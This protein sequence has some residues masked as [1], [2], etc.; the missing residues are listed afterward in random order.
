MKIFI[1]LILLS[2]AAG[3]QVYNQEYNPYGSYGSV[4]QVNSYQ[5][6]RS[7][8]DN[9]QRALDEAH[10]RDRQRLEYQRQEERFRES[11]LSERFPAFAI[12]RQ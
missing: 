1:I 9:G 7:N 5:P 3:A 11:P 4:P 10:A 2:S 6:Y 8:Y 12:P